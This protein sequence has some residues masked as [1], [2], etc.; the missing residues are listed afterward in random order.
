MEGDGGGGESECPPA[1]H[2]SSSLWPLASSG[3]RSRARA[4]RRRAA[5]AVWLG[6]RG[7]VRGG[8]AVVDVEAGMAG[9]D[10][11]LGLGGL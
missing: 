10:A 11:G 4:L 3:C 8:G 1:R 2:C 5:T 7:G 9:A 6:G